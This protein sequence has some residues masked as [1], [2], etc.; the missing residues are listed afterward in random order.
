MTWECWNEWKKLA[1]T[2]S[3]MVYL[4]R[5]SMSYKSLLNDVL[6]K[7]GMP[8]AFIEGQADFSAIAP[9]RDLFISRVIHQAAIDVN[10]EGTQASV[11]TVVELSEKNFNYPW[12][13]MKLN[14]PFIYIIHERQTGIILFMGKMLHP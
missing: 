6:A 1:Q 4:P 13:I 11:A 10:E 9:H 3:G 8:S 5:F 2:D 14:R 12:F 7:M